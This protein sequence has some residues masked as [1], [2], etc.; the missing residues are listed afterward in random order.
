[1]SSDKHITSQLSG[2]DR[3]LNRKFYPKDTVIFEEGEPGHAAYLIQSGEIEIYVTNELGRKKVL[4]VLGHDELFGEMALIDDR[5][6]MASARTTE[7][8]T[9]TIIG[10]GTFEEKLKES[11]PLIRALLNIF[12]EHIRRMSKG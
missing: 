12:V 4:G 8:T 10:Q 2:T 3:I 6:R 9:L 5:P 1:M 7:A 11:D